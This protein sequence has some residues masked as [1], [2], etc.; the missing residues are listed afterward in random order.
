MTHLLALIARAKLILLT[1]EI[2]YGIFKKTS[3]P[4]ATNPKD[5]TVGRGR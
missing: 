1:K 2:R 5:L 3:H 4:R